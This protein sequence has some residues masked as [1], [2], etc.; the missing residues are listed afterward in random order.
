MVRIPRRVLAAIR[1]GLIVA[2]AFMPTWAAFGM[3][4]DQ[5]PLLPGSKV[6]DRPHEDYPRLVLAV[7]ALPEKVSAFYRSEFK[8]RGWVSQPPKKLPQG[9]KG[10]RL[11][12]MVWV[13]KASQ[14]CQVVPIRAVDGG[15]RS[16]ALIL[17]E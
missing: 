17:L 7:P 16:V 12:D 3:T 4:W 9:T 5:V 13:K 1:L 8:R 15:P 14:S 2:A 11:A 6:L 10:A